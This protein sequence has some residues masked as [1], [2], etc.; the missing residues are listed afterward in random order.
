M[1]ATETPIC[2]FGWKAVDFNP[3]GVDGK[4]WSLADVRGPNGTLVMFICKS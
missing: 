4:A 3:T 2:D 1:V